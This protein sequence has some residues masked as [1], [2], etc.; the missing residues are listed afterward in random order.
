MRIAETYFKNNRLI[1]AITPTTA[2]ITAAAATTTTIL[3]ESLD[4]THMSS[5]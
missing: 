4:I 3:D 1:K 2:S 5:L